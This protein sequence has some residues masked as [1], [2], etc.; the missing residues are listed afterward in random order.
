[1]K[2]V[3]LLGLVVFVMVLSSCASIIAPGPDMVP[4]N[5]NPSGADVLYNGNNVGKT[6]VEVEVDRSESAT[7]TLEKDGYNP[8]T[9]SPHKVF[10]GWV[11]GTIFL[12]WPAIVI[13]IV[14]DDFM[15]YSEKPIT[16]TLTEK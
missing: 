13:D 14:N 8:V 4:V 5:S 10:N 12:F 6:P 3:F 1:M 9:I 2:K 16:V 11:V 7:L 15:K